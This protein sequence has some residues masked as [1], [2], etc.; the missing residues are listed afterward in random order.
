[1]QSTSKEFQN[2]E[3]EELLGKEGPCHDHWVAWNQIDKI[4]Y[5]CL[6][7]IAS[8][9]GTLISHPFYVLTTRQQVQLS[10]DKI[11]TNTI[12]KS[13]LSNGLKDAYA[14]IGARGLFRGYLPLLVLNTPS[15]LAY[16]GVTEYTRQRYREFFTILY[17]NCPQLYLDSSQAVF[18]ALLAN[19][20]SVILYTPAEVISSIMIIQ[21]TDNR[22]NLRQASRSLYQANGL[23]GFFRGFN[24]NLAYGVLSSSLWWWTYTVS[25]RW[26]SKYFD[27]T[28]HHFLMDSLCGLSAGVVSTTLIHPLDTVRARIMAGVYEHNKVKIPS[29]MRGMLDIAKSEGHKALWRGLSPSVAATALSSMVFAFTYEFIKRTASLPDDMPDLG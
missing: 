14:K 28:S 27:V 3:M 15:S 2:H 25:R 11:V 12:K 22:Q 6:V 21:N 29:L 4:K 10:G 26:C 9:I 13:S 24:S 18:S 16:L 7:S 17:P 19:F 5:T 8:N 23:S 1:M 20:I